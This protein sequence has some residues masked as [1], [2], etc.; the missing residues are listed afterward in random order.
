MLKFVRKYYIFSTK[1]TNMKKI[2]LALFSIPFFLSC[3]VENIHVYEPTMLT[4]EPASVLTNSATLGG[5]TLS[6]G[7]K[8][9][10]EYG[11]VYSQNDNP[12]TSD[13]KIAL[14]ERLGD[15]YGVYTNFQPSTTYYYRSYGINSIGTGYGET[16]SFT[17]QETA[18]CNPTVDNRIDT[19]FFGTITINDVNLDE[20]PSPLFDG[21]VPFSTES[22][23]S[24]IRI[25]VIFNET[26]ARLP[27][28]GTYHTVTGFDSVAE[29]SVGEVV[30]NLYNYNGSDIGG[31]ASIAGKTIYIQNENGR[32]TFIFC[33][34]EINQYY[35]LDGK[36]TYEP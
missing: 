3:S 31:F 16:Y 28:T 24:I 6:E 2:Y 5:Q 26:L 1:S 11:I 17:T 8:D 20:D 19:G 36:F 22:Y 27:Q 25:E 14:G 12:T 18:A 29:Q 13:T 23:N 32:I 10:T 15:F 33:D 7:G 21:N 30:L 35:T 4:Y 34:V 9:I